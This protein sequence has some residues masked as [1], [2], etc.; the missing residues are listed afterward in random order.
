MLAG[1]QDGRTLTFSSTRCGVALIVYLTVAA[2]CVKREPEE[3]LG[4]SIGLLFA[5]VAAFALPHLRVISFVNFGPV[6]SVASTVGAI[7][8][9]ANMAGPFIRPQRGEGHDAV[10]VQQGPNLLA[11]F[12]VHRRGVSGIGTSE[13]PAVG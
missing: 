6:N 5:I 9:G 8:C 7:L 12:I 13:M 11:V 3:D 2:I 1:W 4:Q 10:P